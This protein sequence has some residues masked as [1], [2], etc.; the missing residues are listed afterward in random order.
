AAAMAR[1][2]LLVP[3]PRPRFRTVEVE[4]ELVTEQLPEPSYALSDNLPSVVVT[5]L[6]RVRLVGHADSGTSWSGLAKGI[7]LVLAGIAFVPGGGG[8]GSRPRRSRRDEPGAA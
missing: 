6:P 8:A 3:N 4:G 7:A 5:T 2:Q 1:Q